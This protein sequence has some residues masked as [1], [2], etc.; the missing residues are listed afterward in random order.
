MKEQ[1][2]AMVARLAASLPGTTYKVDALSS[3]VVMV[4]F[5]RDNAFVVMCYDPDQGFG[6][7]LIGDDDEESGF[8]NRYTPAGKSIEAAEERVKELLSLN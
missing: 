7:D 2:D 5:R 4:D 1:I 8:S 3:G 6:A